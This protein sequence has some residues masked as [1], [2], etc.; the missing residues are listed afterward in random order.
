MTPV[1]LF[2]LDKIDVSEFGFQIDYGL[3]WRKNFERRSEQL[4]VGFIFFD[5]E[6]VSLKSSDDSW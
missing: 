1:K 6:L 5:G 2:I 4:T 3:I